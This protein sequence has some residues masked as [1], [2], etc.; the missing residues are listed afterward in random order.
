[1][2]RGD[3]HRAD[4]APRG[5]P[6]HGTSN[7]A[8]RKAALVAASDRARRALAAEFAPV[9]ALDTDAR[10]VAARLAG[11]ARQPVVVGAVVLVL[12]AAGPRRVLATLRWAIVGAAPLL[13]PLLPLAAERLASVLAR[14]PPAGATT[15][16]APA[17][18]APGPG[19]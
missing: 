5:G 9:S 4:A 11:L 8:A 15:S 13:R 17:S 6:G 10:R 19:A 16:T 18:R 12:V 2:T 3:Q 1:V 14:R 7:S